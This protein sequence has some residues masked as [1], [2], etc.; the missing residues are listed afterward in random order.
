MAYIK[1]DCYNSDFTEYHHKNIRKDITLTDL[2]AI[3]FRIM[4]DKTERIRAI[5]YK[6]T[7]E[8]H[9]PMQMQ[10]LKRFKA[11]FNTLNKIASKTKFELFMITADFRGNAFNG[12]YFL[13]DD[14]AIIFNFIENKTRKINESNLIS[15]LNFN[16][17]WENLEE[18]DGKKIHRVN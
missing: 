1:P 10:V 2:D 3:Q 9:R 13:K 18:I 8:A 5:E 14:I 15:F 7:Y 4:E 16:K 11:Y 17:E 12:D 6:G